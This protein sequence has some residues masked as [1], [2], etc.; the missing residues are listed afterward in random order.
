[1]TTQATDLT[2][3]GGWVEVAGSADDF[4]VE[5]TGFG[6]VKVTL[7]AAA[8]AADAPF[9]TIKRGEAMVRVGT[10][11]CY[12]ASAGLEASVVVTS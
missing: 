4:L 5:N 6:D 2:R 9:H 7:Q 1:M 3:A 10:G 11:A 12:V 8:P